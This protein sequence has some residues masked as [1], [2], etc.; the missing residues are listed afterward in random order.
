M[1]YRIGTDNFDIEGVNAGIRGDLAPCAARQR[2]RID[3]VGNDGVAEF[4]VVRGQRVADAIPG[5]R[6]RRRGSR[7]LAERVLD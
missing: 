2:Q 3:R 6:E 5:V 1:F 7:R 4:E